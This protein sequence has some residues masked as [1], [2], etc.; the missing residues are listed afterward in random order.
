MRITR[1]RPERRE[2]RSC[3]R[4][5]VAPV[6]S[7][8]ALVWIE[9]ARGAIH[10][11]VAAG[12]E[13]P[14]IDRD[15]AAR[16]T[17][18]LDLWEASAQEGPT[19]AL[20][21]E[22]PHDE[23]EFLAHAF[24]R[25]SDRWTADADERGF[26][27]SPR[28]GDE[29]YTA[30]VDAVI[31]GLEHADDV[32]G[33]EF[34]TALRTIWPRVERLEPAATIEVRRSTPVEVRLA[35]GSSAWVVVSGPADG[36]PVLFV[37]GSATSATVVDLVS[38]LSSEQEALGLRLISVERNGFGDTPFD[39]TAGYADFARTAIGVLDAVGVDRFSIVA[40]SGGGPYAQHVATAAPQRVRSL[41]LAAAYTGVPDGGAVR[42]YCRLDAAERSALVAWFC[43]DPPSW[44]TFADDSFVRGIP[45][46]LEAAEADAR[47]ALRDPA[48]VSHEFDLFC[49][50]I[51]VD[52]SVVT[53]P[54]FLYYSPDDTATPLEFA[55][56]YAERLPNVVFDRR[57]LTGNHDE[58][59]RHWCQI[60]ADLESPHA[61]ES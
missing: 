53:A 57:D 34:G 20:S 47:R 32:S 61:A 9:F 19:L 6:P 60:L 11:A 17:G 42:S 46:F 28:E 45:G 25:I 14:L 8:S 27:I 12:G 2:Y 41:H 48:A 37:G 30:L 26:D 22:I 23:V 40:I 58:Q 50:P 39:P 54:S 24:L 49:N 51:D 21:F 5:I 4:V 59:Y 36:T 55:D 3:V 18:I 1:E 44:W 56:W 35:D 10:D 13:P 31:V 38:F 33:A 43:G 7:S 29:F 16:L 52:L 15:L